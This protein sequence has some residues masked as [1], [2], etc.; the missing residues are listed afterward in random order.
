LVGVAAST[1]GFAVALAVGIGLGT[2]TVDDTP[3]AVPVDAGKAVEEEPGTGTWVGTSVGDGCD[4]AVAEA[5]AAIVT[6]G[7]TGEVAVTAD[8]TTATSRLVPPQ[9][10]STRARPAR[11]SILKAF[12]RDLSS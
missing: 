3:A 12:I 10:A 7:R 5:G 9:A 8:D 6:V 2:A 4:T 11:S 1:T